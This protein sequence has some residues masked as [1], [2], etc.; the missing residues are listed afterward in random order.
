MH[1]Y[2]LPMISV[3]VMYYKY[4]L[5]KKFKGVYEIWHSKRTLLKSV[6]R[7]MMEQRVKRDR[8]NSFSSNAFTS[9]CSIHITE[10]IK[11]IFLINTWF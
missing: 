10:Q 6:A 1:M 8:K 5:A 11:H 4:I 9:F 3:I 2:K 7:I